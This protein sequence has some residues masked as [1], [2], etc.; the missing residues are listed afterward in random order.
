[1]KFSER[2]GYKPIREVIQIESMDEPLRNGLWSLLQVHCRE[3]VHHSSGAYGGYYLNEL[4]NEEIHGE[5]QST[6]K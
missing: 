6:T 3:H 5:S 4:G 1:M 2:Y